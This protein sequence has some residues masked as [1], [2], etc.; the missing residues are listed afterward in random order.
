M[1]DAEPAPSNQGRA[2]GASKTAAKLKFELTARN[3][4][5]VGKKISFTLQAIN[6]SMEDYVCVWKMGDSSPE[7]KGSSVTHVFSQEGNY[8]ATGA[9]YK[10]G[11]TSGQAIQSLSRDITIAPAPTPKK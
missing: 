5:I 8:H 4:G 7:I 1:V 11:D 2:A 6:G 3:K 9:L 10:R